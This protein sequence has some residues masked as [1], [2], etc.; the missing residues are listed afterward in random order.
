MV[1]KAYPWETKLAYIEMKR[2]GKSN[3]VIMET[4]GIK[5]DSQ[6]Y[7]WETGTKMRIFIVSIKVLESNIPMVKAQNICLKWNCYNY[8][9][10]S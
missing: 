1:K 5:N 9:L 10:T 7:I 4:L 8:R 3:R 2:A 6:I